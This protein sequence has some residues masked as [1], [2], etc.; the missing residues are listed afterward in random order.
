MIG[1]LWQQLPRHQRVVD[2]LDHELRED[3]LDVGRGELV[4]FLL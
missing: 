4:I 2:L 3:R 1:T